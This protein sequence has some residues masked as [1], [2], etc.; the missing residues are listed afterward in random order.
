MKKQQ[1][2]L[3]I[4]IPALNEE[5]RIGQSL[6]K[7]ASFIISNPSM[8]GVKCEVIVVSADCVDKTHEIALQ[9]AHRFKNFS[10]VKAGARVGKGRDVRLGM[11]TTR[12]KYALFMDADLATPLHHIATTLDLLRN[13]AD[14]V[15]GVRDLRKMHKNSFRRLISVTGNLLFRLTSGIPISDT[16]CGFKAFTQASLKTIFKKQTIQG[17]GFDMELITIGRL[18][19]LKIYSLPISD[20]ENG[21]GSTLSNP[22]RSAMLTLGDLIRITVN[23]VKK[24]YT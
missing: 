21:S 23:R 12:G 15:I 17:W 19:G 14:I 8:Q 24:N 20:W 5:K 18:H 11:L 6:D 7:L 22:L 10:L 13:H 2:D 1:I 3:S 4:V 9:Y 16:Q